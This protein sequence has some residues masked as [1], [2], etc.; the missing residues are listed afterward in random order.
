MTAMIKSI[1]ALKTDRKGVTALEYALIASAA[2]AVI[3]VAF[4]AFFTR[5]QTF[6]AGISFS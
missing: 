2:A 5:I 3:L 1:T 4:N 6:L